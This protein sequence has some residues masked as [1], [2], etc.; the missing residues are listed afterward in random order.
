MNNNREVFNTLTAPA[1]TFRG[2]DEPPIIALCY[3][4]GVVRFNQSASA[5][6]GLSAQSTVQF[7]R[8][9]LK[10]W[11]IVVGAK[12]G[13]TVRTNTKRKGGKPYEQYMF[14]HRELVRRI[15]AD[16]GKKGTVRIPL[17]KVVAGEWQLAIRQATVRM[18]KSKQE[19]TAQTQ[20]P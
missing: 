7:E 16:V 4:T 14:G 3:S 17:D 1:N 12:E 8:D 5:Q 15:L 19:T 6:L 10:D 13:F 2:A 18:E 11:F 20:T 9:R